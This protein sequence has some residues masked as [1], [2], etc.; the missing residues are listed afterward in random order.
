MTDFSTVK[1]NL[2]QRGFAV[3]T[4][5]T[6]AEAA[7]YLTHC[8]AGK[9]VS[10]GGSMTLEAMG[11][12]DC[13]CKSSTVYSHWHPIEGMSADELRLRAMTTEAYL[14]SANGLAE[15]GEIINIDGTG[16]RVAAT[17]FGHETV[18][19]VIGRNKLAPDYDAALWR[20]R[21]I[22]APK[23]A[24]RLGMPTPCAVNGDRCYDCKSPK[25][26]CRGLVVLWEAVKSCR[27]EIVL[28]DEDL[29]Y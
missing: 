24:Q 15:T 12:Y 2:E 7:D 23:N 27:T 3:S 8:L 6:A 19:F 11:M 13:L 4:F 25:R 29:G 22:A 5:A 10:F 14:T 26:I 20:A 1:Q 17:L 16:N 9:T 28:V 21:N 18:Y